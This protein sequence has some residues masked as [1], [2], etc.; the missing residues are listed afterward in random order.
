MRAEADPN[1]IVFFGG[2]YMPLAEARVGILTHALHY[3]SGVLERIRAHWDEE[4][5]ELFAMRPW[6]TLSGGNRTAES[7]GL[8]FRKLRRHCAR[9]LC[10]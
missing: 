1:L 3:G 5:Q 10:N 4:R 7:C 6:S 9:S 2:E 8:L